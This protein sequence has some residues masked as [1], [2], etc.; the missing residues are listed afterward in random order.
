L[1][2]E[3]IQHFFVEHDNHLTKKNLGHLIYSVLQISMNRYH[4]KTIFGKT[5]FPDNSV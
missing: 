5:A 2:I 4:P 3:I 1:V